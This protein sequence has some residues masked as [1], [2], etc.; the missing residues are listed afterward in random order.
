MCNHL[1]CTLFVLFGLTHHW[2]FFS[3]LKSSVGYDWIPFGRKISRFNKSTNSSKCPKKTIQNTNT[4]SSISVK[5]LQWNT[6]SYLQGNKLPFYTSS[7]HVL[8]WILPRLLPLDLRRSTALDG[9]RNFQGDLGECQEVVPF[10]IGN[11]PGQS[12]P[13]KVPWRISDKRIVYNMEFCTASEEVPWN[14]AWSGADD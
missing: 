5:L 1:I 8:Q 14:V 7:Q 10:Q 9:F 4:T 2:I 6:I 12:L 3:P 13:G 11:F